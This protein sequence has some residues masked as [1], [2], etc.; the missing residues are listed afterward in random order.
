MRVGWP[1]TRGK[2]IA[3]GAGIGALVLFV[4]WLIA[5]Y[6]VVVDPTV[7]HP[8][9][10]DVI[11]VLGPPDN[12]GRVDTAL[13]LIH[14]HVASNLVISVMSERQR[15]VKHV[16]TDPQDGFTV[17]CFQPHP[18][19]TRGEAEHI[20][21]LARQHGWRSVVVVTSTY[22]VSRA[23][24]I[25]HRCLDGPLYLVAARRGISWL[26]WGYQ[27]LYQTGGYVKAALQSG[28]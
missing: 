27:Y 15:Q 6:L 20:R 25:F 4:A 12:N 11:V 14:R 1:A 26:T 2:R 28:C 21:D 23:R 10:A 5:G 18:A 24:V 19:T 8:E 9:H 17:I 7:N 3:A 16:C 13:D 22:H